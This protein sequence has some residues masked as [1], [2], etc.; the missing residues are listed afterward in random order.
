MPE[1]K[2]ILMQGNEAC[3]EGAINAGVRFFAGYPI[4]PSTEVAELMAAK[5][6]DIGGVFMQMEDEIASMAAVIGASIGGMRAITATSGPGFSLKQE[7][8]GFAVM[9]EIPCVVVNVQRMGPSTGVPTAPSQGDVMQSRWGTHGDHPIIVFSPASVYETYYLTIA[10]V[11]LSQKL[12]QPVVLL[13]DEV[14]GHMREKVLIPGGG[15]LIVEKA[16]DKAPADWKPYDDKGVTPLVP[17][18]FGRYYHVTGLYH[19]QYGFPTSDPCQVER[20]L[21]R[22]HDKLKN[23]RDEVVLTNYIGHREPKVAI[24]AYGCTVRSA[25]A[26]IKK[27]YWQNRLPVGLLSLQTI[28]P[29]PDR[30]IKELAEKA[31]VIIV[32]ELNMGQLVGEVERCACGRAEVIPLNRYDGEMITPDQLVEKMGRWLS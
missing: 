23:Y 30:E 8:L 29:F 7:N 18:G 11:N 27:A 4:T 14:I 9:A 31:D 12:R 25:R 1:T 24:V 2:P 5:L 10:A 15:K 19:D 32:P 22:L 13:L 28:W 26:V 17:F 6:P 20:A 21:D 16:S 3:A